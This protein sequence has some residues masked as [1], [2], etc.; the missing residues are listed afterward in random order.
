MIIFM[1]TNIV[2]GILFFVVGLV[3]LLF[4]YGIIPVGIFSDIWQWII[5]VIFFI[6]AAA[7]IVFSRNESKLEEVKK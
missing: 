3:I 7:I 6:I 2:W 4:S 1:K 5:P